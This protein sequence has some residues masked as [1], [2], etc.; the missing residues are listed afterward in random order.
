MFALATPPTT[1]RPISW[2]EV[3][4]T[5]NVT[6]GAAERRRNIKRSKTTPFI[7]PLTRNREITGKN[8]FFFAHKASGFLQLKADFFF[9]F[10]QMSRFCHHD[11]AL[12]HLSKAFF[13]FGTNSF[14]WRNIFDELANLVWKRKKEKE[15]QLKEVGFNCRCSHP[16]Q[17]FSTSE[18]Y[19]ILIMNPELLLSFI[20]VGCCSTFHRATS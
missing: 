5:R 4:E 1:F 17:R 15:A 10:F 13:N 3:F 9:F 20:S 14:R 19:D 16:S 7:P 11:F 12:C 18:I 8:F 6:G 2:M